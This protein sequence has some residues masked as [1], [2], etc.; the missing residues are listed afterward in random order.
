MEDL[1]TIKKAKYLKDF[2]IEILFSNGET[3]IINLAGRLNGKIFQPLNNLEY[4]KTVRLNPDLE[5][6]SWDNGADFAPEYLFEIG[7]TKS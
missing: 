1:L 6:I 2:E 4:F 5:T 7:Q 3:K